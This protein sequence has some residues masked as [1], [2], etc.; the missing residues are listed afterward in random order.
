MKKTKWKNNLEVKQ[1]WQGLS[2]MC[3]AKNV[4]HGT[5]MESMTTAPS[6]ASDA[7]TT[8]LPKPKTSSLNRQ[9]LM[10]QEEMTE[11]MGFL[12]ESFR[13]RIARYQKPSSNMLH[14]S[15]YQSHNYWEAGGFTSQEPTPS[16][17]STK[18]L[19]ESCAVL[20][21]GPLEV[22]GKL[23]PSILTGDQPTTPLT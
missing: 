6:G 7:T 13:N 2:D 16:S 8:A 17:S 10:S 21:Q 14:D 1:Q 4:A 20:K 3:A 19:T 15:I 5:I 11:L 23:T 22:K 9:M 12:R 18:T